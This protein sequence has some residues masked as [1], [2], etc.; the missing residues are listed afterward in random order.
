MLMAPARVQPLAAAAIFLLLVQTLIGAPLASRMM[1]ESALDASAETAPLCE[2]H[3]GAGGHESPHPAP[4]PHHHDHE[5][6]VLCQAS[7]TPL[8]A[9]GGALPSLA[10]VV[11]P[12]E[13]APFFAFVQPSA[14]HAHVAEARAPP[15]P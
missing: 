2:A 11:N 8:L 10:L 6:C 14:C 7:A 15:A 3:E 5:H 1:L 13:R 4:A 12:V 9:A